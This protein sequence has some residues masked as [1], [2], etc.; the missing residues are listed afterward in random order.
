VVLVG[1]LKQPSGACLVTI[2]H[3]GRFGKYSK[4]G[5][6]KSDQLSYNVKRV[7]SVWV[8][9]RVL[10]LKFPDNTGGKMYVTSVWKPKRP[11]CWAK[12]VTL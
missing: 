8:C 12:T 3:T 5:D 10:Q 9:E 11:L 7:K 4:A 1:S 6:S 2:R